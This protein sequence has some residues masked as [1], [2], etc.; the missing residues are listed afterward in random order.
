MENWKISKAQGLQVTRSRQRRGLWTCPAHRY[1]VPPL[2][3]IR[4]SAPPFSFADIV[5]A[6][7]YCFGSP[8]L[9]VLN[10]LNTGLGGQNNSERNGNTWARP[11]FPFAQIF[12]NVSKRH[13]ERNYKRS[14][15]KTTRSQNILTTQILMCINTMKKCCG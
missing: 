9:C 2:R 4:V 14:D 6:G 1:P 11:L 8:L 15:E 10:W 5:D 13:S 3:T 12:I 7:L